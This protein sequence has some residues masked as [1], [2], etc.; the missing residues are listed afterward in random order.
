MRIFLS[1]VLCFFLFGCASSEE[2]TEV[3][4][5]PHPAAY[6][7]DDFSPPVPRPEREPKRLKFYFKECSVT[8]SKSHY[9]STAYICDDINN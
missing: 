8:D 1:V 2:N 6:S 9:S 7:M 3:I 5:R 4:T